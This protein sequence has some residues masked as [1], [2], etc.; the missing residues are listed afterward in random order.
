MSHALL[1]TDVVDS[2]A[3]VE[4]L[5]DQEAA[6]LWAEHD[7][8]AR[9]L[10]H[11]CGGREIDHSDG[12][13]LLFDEVTQAAHYALAYHRA[14]AELAL[15]AR[16]GL[17]VGAVTLRENAAS[18][19]ARG[20]K[21][22]EVEGI[23]KPLAARIMA[24]A[25]G[26]QTLLSAAASQALGDRL[27]AGAQLESH[28]HYRLK[29]VESP[30]QIFELGVPGQAP[31]VPPA[32]ADKGYRV[33][34]AGDLWRPL[35]EVR[36]NLPAERDAFVGRREEL[37]TLA[38]RLDAGARL[39][40]VLGVGGTGKT[41][42]VRRYGWS[43]LGD[44]PGGIYFCDLSEA[45]SLEGIVFAVA[46]A[47]SVPL[48]KDDAVVQL[49]HAIAG[50]GRCLVM[51][52]NFEQVIDHARATL[53]HWLDRAAE[54]AFLVTSRERLHLPGEEVLPL[55][56]L[57]LAGE[58][59]EL[60]ATRAKAQ[61]PDFSLGAG[62]RAAVAEVVRLLDGLPLAIE[63]AAARISILSPAQLLERLKDR[64]KLLAGARGA[65][66][67][68]ATLKAAIDWSWQLLSAWEQAAFAQCA[69]FEGGFT[70]QAAEAVLDLSPWPE[71]PGTIDVV[72]AL[73][74]KCL[75]RSWVPIEQ[76]R[77][78]LDEPYF[79]MYVSI[80]EYANEK[81]LASGA[82]SARAAQQRHGRYFATFGT[83]EA[84]ESLSRHGG[85]KKRRLLV[86]ELDNLVI[87]CQRAVARND[88]HTAVAT[89]R[90]AWEVLELQ[91][92]LLLGVTIGERV[93]SAGGIDARQ[94]AAALVTRSKALWRA[95]RVDEADAGFVQA[96]AIAREL[97]DDA[98]QGDALNALGA[99]NYELNRLETAGKC[100]DEALTIRRRI[101]DLPGEGATLINLANLHLAHGRTEE[102]DDC[103]RAALRILRDV[104]NRRDEGKALGNM[105]VIHNNHGRM[106]EALTHYEQALA[107]DRE[108]GN[109]RGESTVLNNIA[110]MHHEQG[111]FPEASKCYDA[112]LV[113]AREVGDRRIEGRLLA[114]LGTLNQELNRTEEARACYT[115]A[116]TIHRE[117]RDRGFEGLVLG[118]L[119][120]LLFRQGH[121]EDARAQFE[122][123]LEIARATNDRRNEG[124]T[125]G[126]LADLLASQGK[127]DEALERL[128]S[129][130]VLLRDIGDQ[131][132][133]GKLLCI[134]GRA[135][136][137][138]GRAVDARAALAE[139]NALAA[140]TGAGP[141]SELQREI[142]RL[143]AHL[144]RPHL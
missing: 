101:G 43:W 123:A 124:T 115:T 39:V 86:L 11:R 60:F 103:Y 120:V 109:R 104:G 84:I 83:D 90:A 25:G 88:A 142:A 55:E 51:L 26:G 48:G 99:L 40:S 129:G 64:F 61:R 81:L 76:G 107:I 122:A 70:L 6:G 140:A 100:L 95:G 15:V 78:D 44:W 71:A 112:A 79:G 5:G 118:N 94:R 139:A 53:G 143:R 116:L 132:E 92:P 82:S 125:L 111:R 9:E 50:R 59:I 63:L 20:A 12:F 77:Y 22:R 13:F 87:A 56:P 31:F 135:D 85:V 28:G 52:D 35:R 89:Y 102:T 119:G 73:V 127:L 62:N 23:A 54:A 67:R 24:L 105:G 74:D 4:R 32:D 93:L 18:D 29:G 113:V 14:I 96:L 131:M 137:V 98:W 126:S 75:L 144:D 41:R 45:R 97:D 30:L 108:L 2:T 128:R 72:Q 117:V 91:G 46:S 38:T 69:V 27:P 19:I 138:A 49:G 47:L 7:R 66:Q 121:V 57:P 8:R 114:N 3:L 58:A 36:H 10:L 42:L 136:L 68:Q 37:R 65:A 130:E 141:E 133:L 80:H 110:S 134:R 34:L 1:F 106:A 33:V 16:A 17:H 21:P